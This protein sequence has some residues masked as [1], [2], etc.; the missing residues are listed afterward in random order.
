MFIA[1]LADVDAIPSLVERITGSFG[2]PD[3]LVNNAGVPK[4]RQVAA[5]TMD[6]VESVMRMNYFSPVALTLAVLPGM[7]ERGSGHVVNISSMGAHMVSFGVGAYAATKGALEYFTEAM[8]LELRGTGVHAH[9]VV[10][11]STRSEFSTPKE[12]NDPPFPTDPATRVG[13]EVVADAIVACLSDHRFITY[14]TEREQATSAARNA[15]PNTFL[16]SMGERLAA[17]GR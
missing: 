8:Y 1:D 7:R 10:P 3:V 14:A 4:R 15:D 17:L 5:L 12:G 13:P 9:V 16:A 6:D 2:L 11:G